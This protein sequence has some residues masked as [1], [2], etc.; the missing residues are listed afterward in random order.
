MRSGGAVGR[1]FAIVPSDLM[2]GWRIVHGMGPRI[3]RISTQPR[4]RAPTGRAIAPSSG[5]LG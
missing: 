5:G 4:R 1:R 2:A 3:V